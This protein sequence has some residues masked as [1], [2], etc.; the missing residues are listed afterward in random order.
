MQEEQRKRQPV[1]LT[2]Y[3]LLSE[4]ADASFE[5]S[6]S[7]TDDD[8]DDAVADNELGE[9]KQHLLHDGSTEFGGSFGPM[10]TLATTSKG[11]WTSQENGSVSA[12]LAS[13]SA[14]NASLITP[15]FQR[16]RQ[17]Q[18][19][20]S[21]SSWVRSEAQR[22]PFSPQGTVSPHL[23]PPTIQLLPDSQ[24]IF[25]PCRPGLYTCKF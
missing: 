4:S 19:R 23:N 1:T 25:A 10:S 5:A 12:R 22:T 7:T 3:P 11:L 2:V 21:V 18:R 24:L 17:Y 9:G 13:L 14:T 6:C 15:P 20:A 16:H 8:N